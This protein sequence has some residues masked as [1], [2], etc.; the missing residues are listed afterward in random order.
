MFITIK[1]LVY[2]AMSVTVIAHLQGYKKFN[3]C[4]KEII[5]VTS[6]SVIACIFKVLHATLRAYILYFKYKYTQ[7]YS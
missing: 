1:Y 6:H 5:S 2:N 3:G 7:K 4:I